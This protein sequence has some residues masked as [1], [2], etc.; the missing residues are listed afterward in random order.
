LHRYLQEFVYRTNRPR[1]EADLFIYL[2]RRAVNGEPPT[3]LR[4]TAEGSG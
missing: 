1:L 4:L 2:L 3:W